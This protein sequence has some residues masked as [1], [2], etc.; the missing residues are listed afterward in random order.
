VYKKLHENFFT[1]NK[2]YFGYLLFY[3]RKNMADLIR[4][5]ILAGLGI[6]SITKEK[7][8]KLVKDLIKEG[9]LSETEEAKFIK[10]IMKKSE[11]IGDN[12]DKKIEE[13]VEKTLKKLNIPTRKDLDDIKQKLDKLVKQKTNKS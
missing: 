11:K 8:E 3:E 7:A 12:V 1:T 2:V 9:K 6:T 5:L 10:D 13:M 4:N